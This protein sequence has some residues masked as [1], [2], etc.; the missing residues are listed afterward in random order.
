MFDR[1]FFSYVFCVSLGMEKILFV[2]G[3]RTVTLDHYDMFHMYL[4]NEKP[5]IVLHGGAAGADFVTRV[6]C[7][8]EG[9]EQKKYFPDYERYGKLA[10]LVRNNLMVDAATHALFF[11]LNRDSMQRGGT[12]QA[13]ARWRRMRPNAPYCVIVLNDEQPQ[14]TALF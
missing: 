7:D 5:D 1:A 9:V 10:P 13:L 4:S 14:Q 3:N 8:T 6:W 12:C 11:F 2:S